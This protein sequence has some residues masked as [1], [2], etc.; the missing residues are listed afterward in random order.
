M[1]DEREEEDVGSHFVRLVPARYEDGF[2][3]KPFHA[4]EKACCVIEIAEEVCQAHKRVKVDEVGAIYRNV[5]TS[6]DGVAKTN[7]LWSVR[8]TMGA[9]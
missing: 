9:H 3:G 1:L 4:D 7:D 8:T 2:V 5:M 6:E